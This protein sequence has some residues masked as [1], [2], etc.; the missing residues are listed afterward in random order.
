MSASKATTMHCMCAIRGQ[1]MRGEFKR[2]LRVHID[3]SDSILFEDERKEVN[4]GK[5]GSRLLRTVA[6]PTL[7]PKIPIVI[8][9]QTNEK[10]NGEEAKNELDVSQRRIRADLKGLH[11]VY[12]M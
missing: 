5:P 9:S 4:Y 7:K 10:K 3:R 2:R 1:I 6:S 12:C 8:F 11:R